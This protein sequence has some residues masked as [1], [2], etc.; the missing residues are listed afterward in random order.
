MLKKSATVRNDIGIRSRAATLLIQKAREFSSSVHMG[1]NNTVVNCKSSLGVLSC[2]VD[3]GSVIDIIT[4]GTDEEKALSAMIEL[5]E[6][7]FTIY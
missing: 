6:S 1:Y 7:G 5:V 2:P 4:D 3:S